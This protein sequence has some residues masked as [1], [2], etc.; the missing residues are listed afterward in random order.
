MAKWYRQ[1]SWSK[2]GLRTLPDILL[3]P[4]RS[5]G[6]VLDTFGPRQLREGR[7][8]LSKR[9]LDER[10][11]VLLDTLAHDASCIAEGRLS[12]LWTMDHC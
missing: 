10:M 1:S 8:A 12:S 2:V 5:M 9:R 6:E 4:V 11:A 3:H 7:V